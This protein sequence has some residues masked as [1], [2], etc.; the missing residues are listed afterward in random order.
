MIEKTAR[1]KIEAARW[2]L[3]RGVRENDPLARPYLSAAAFSLILVGQG[4]ENGCPT[5]GVDENWRLYWNPEF[6]ERATIPELVAYLYHELCHLLRNHHERLRYVESHVVANL[7]ADLEINDDLQSEGYPKGILQHPAEYGFQEHLLAEQYVS[8]LRDRDAQL[9]QGGESG[10]PASSAAR[11][12][13]GSG[14]TGQRAGGADADQASAPPSG[15]PDSR[16]PGPQNQSGGQGTQGRAQQ[17]G[18]QSQNPGQSHDQGSEGA[19]QQGEGGCSASSGGQGQHKP[20]PSCGSGAHGRRQPWEYG[21]GEGPRGLSGPEVQIIKDLTARQIREAAKARGDIPGSWLR[22]AETVT[23]QPRVPWRRVLTCEILR[24]VQNR[25]GFQDYSWARPSR[26]QGIVRAGE[27]LR[28]AAVEPELRIAAVIDT[29]GSVSD[30][31]LAVAVTEVV[32]GLARRLQAEVVVIPCDTKAGE[33]IRGVRVP[34]KL[35][36]KL[37]GGGG[38]DMRGGIARAEAEKPSVIIVF[39]DGDT[40]WPNKAPQVPVVVA[41]SKREFASQVPSWAKLVVVG[42]GI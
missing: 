7:A 32:F 11:Q 17:D 2:R 25:L 15:G 16:E 4:K 18:P 21:P 41:L 20:G 8:L 19:G 35:K 1:E 29:S 42:E 26:R 30:R 40:P 31:E 27:P 36:T 13:Q 10:S 12:N 34:E 37:V 5:I 38:T 6:V 14:R 23:A 28:P 33:V 9:G 3:V 39:T 22:W 24:R